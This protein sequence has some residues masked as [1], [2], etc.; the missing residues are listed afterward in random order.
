MSPLDDP[1]DDSS[2]GARSDDRIAALEREVA[3]LRADVAFLR[4]VAGAAAAAPPS[5]PRQ[6]TGFVDPMIAAALRKPPGQGSS[7][8]PP[9]PRD[10]FS[11]RVYSGAA[12]SADE[13]ESMVGRYATLALAGLVILMAVGAVIKMAV[14][15]GLLTPEVRV[16][17]GALAA[18]A[19]AIA[20]VFFRRRGAVRYG[21]VLLA[22]SLAVVDL[23][24]WG[25]GPR[26]HLVPTPVALTIVDVVAIALALLALRDESEFLF[27]VAIA[28]ALSA[29]F[30]TSDGGG[31]AI[32][33]LAY[34]A[35]VLA[36][37]LRSAREPS[38][39]LAFGVLV[40]GA[41]VY[42]LAAAA[43]PTEHT[44]WGAY[45]VAIFGA[46]C[47]AAALLF[48]EREWRGNLPR[49][50][51]A[52]TLIGVLSGWD[53][54]SDHPFAV[55]M[56]VAVAI[57]AVTYAALLVRG[58]STRAWTASA[59]VLP[60][61]SLGIA[62]GGA[63]TGNIRGA[64]VGL[65]ALFASAAW[66]AERAQ[67]DHG[68]AGAHLLAAGMLGACALTAWLWPWPL[69]LVGGL[70]A[71]SIV[72]AA[73]VRN[74]R[75]L[76][77]LIGVGISVGSAIVSAL[78]QL[79]SRSAYSYSPFLTRSSV[80]ALFAAIAIAGAG[81]FIRR[82]DGAARD[83]VDRP[84]RIGLLVAFLIWWGRMEVAHAISVDV[85]GFLLTSYYAAC[86]LSSIIAGRQMGLRSLRV[87]GL[88]LAIY[89]AL[90][91]VVEVTNIESIALRVG[92]YAAVGVLLL[93][94]GYLYRDRGE[95]VS[96]AETMS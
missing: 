46:T 63:T 76:L 67:N 83:L 86:G 66:R 93:G 92:A 9:G 28:G 20:G 69:F 14:Q 15:R 78:D 16:L 40:A 47:A 55:T 87:A 2:E 85:A 79:A 57:A 45:L 75:T 11:Q 96:A 90:K 68:R 19:I 59:I 18:V 65:W 74:E 7:P 61:V 54:V 17:A 25:A 22:L 24:A 13:L 81:D 51:L 60:L 31:R 56:A 70:A 39:R 94:A 29:P 32:V 5:E 12:I 37:G 50:Y 27:A 8:P 84:G 44:W 53:A 64:V 73:L 43:L 82:G 52:V 88:A 10:S 34:G 72:L 21:N 35:T 41:F 89:A 6:A 4:R 62:Y 36:G 42:S 49:A 91:A 48:G 26:F 33:L 1:P 23:V 77:P 30:V 58:V 38:W 71:W 3:A 95:A 80:S